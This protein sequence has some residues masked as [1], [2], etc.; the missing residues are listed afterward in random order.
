VNI[1]KLP[2]Y[3]QRILTANALAPLCRSHVF[4]K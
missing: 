4:R 2:I 3:L 1:A